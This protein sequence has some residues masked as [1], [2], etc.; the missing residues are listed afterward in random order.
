MKPII[1]INNDHVLAGVGARY[2]AKADGVLTLRPI[3][4][5]AVNIRIPRRATS[6]L[7]NGGESLS[8]GVDAGDAIAII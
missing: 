3:D 5:H 2:V 6:L 4:N 8:I 7:M 1:S